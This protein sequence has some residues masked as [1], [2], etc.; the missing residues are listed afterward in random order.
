MK[1]IVIDIDEMSDIKEVYKETPNPAIIYTIYILFFVLGVG[2]F[3]MHFFKLD[4]VV[5][6]NGVLRNNASVYEVTSDI[7]GK[8]TK[9][10]IQNGEHVNCCDTLYQIGKKKIVAPVSGHFWCNN[11]LKNGSLIS[12]GMS[13]GRIYLGN[14]SEFYTEFYVDNYNI[15]DIREGQNVKFEILAYPKNKYG[16]FKGKVSS[17]SNDTVMDEKN[18]L[19]YYVVK[20]KC[21]DMIKKA[22]VLKNLNFR[23]GMICNGSIVVGKKTIMNYLLEK[24]NLIN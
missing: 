9:C 3:W 15:G 5:K 20:V 12:K 19:T 18:G 24:L 13:L 21:F 14:E 11:N 4:D 17:I 23:N 10:N 16:C 22:K 1:P 2:S 6:S 8:I 7:S